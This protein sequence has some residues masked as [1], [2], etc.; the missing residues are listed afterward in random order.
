VQGIVL[1]TGFI[2]VAVSF[3]SDAVSGWLD[4]RVRAS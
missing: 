3:L 1:V 4:P 2:V